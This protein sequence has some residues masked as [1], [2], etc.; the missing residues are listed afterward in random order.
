[1][2]NLTRDA[3]GQVQGRL[4]ENIHEDR[5]DVRFVPQKVDAVIREYWTVYLLRGGGV[6]R[7]IHN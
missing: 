6:E 3:A 4:A 7:K 5:F 1:M 2:K